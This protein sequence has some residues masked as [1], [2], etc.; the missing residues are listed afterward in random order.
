MEVTGHKSVLSL[1]VY[2]RV[3]S[4]EKVD[5]RQAIARCIDKSIV[6]VQTNPITTT[7]I[8]VMMMNFSEILIYKI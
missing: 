3:S 8:K 7:E 6:P 1:A 4:S 2:Q 5:M